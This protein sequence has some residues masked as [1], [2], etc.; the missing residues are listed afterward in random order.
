[1]PGYSTRAQAAMIVATMGI[2]NFLRRNEGLDEGFHRAKEVDNDEIEIELLDEKDEMAAK[3]DAI[4][5]DD[6]P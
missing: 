5:E 6:V 4:V 2:H 1:M 3:R